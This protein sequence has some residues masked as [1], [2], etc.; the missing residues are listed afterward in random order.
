L[1]ILL[2][3]KQEKFVIKFK[4]TKVSLFIHKNVLFIYSQTIITFKN[5]T[6]PYFAV[7]PQFL[8]EGILNTAGEHSRIDQG[9]TANSN[10]GVL[11]CRT[12]GNKNKFFG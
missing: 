3:P 8:R 6:L 9:K 7:I 5:F 10:C 2:H 11:R 1:T 12:S 4:S